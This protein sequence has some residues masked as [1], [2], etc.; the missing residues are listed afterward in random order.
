MKPVG[1]DQ[2]RIQANYD[3]GTNEIAAF[4]LSFAVVFAVLHARA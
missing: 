3:A 4:F 2:T 1:I